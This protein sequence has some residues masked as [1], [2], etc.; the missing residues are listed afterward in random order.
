[1]AEQARPIEDAREERLNAAILA[2]LQAKAE[3]RRLERDALAARYPDVAEELHAFLGAEEAVGMAL[4]PWG[5]AAPPSTESFGS[6]DVEGV[7]N[8]GGMGVIL[9]CRDRNL[10]RS[11]A[12]KLPHAGATNSEA[13]RRFHEEAQITSQ[14]QHP[15]V[16]PVHELGRH[17]DGRPY[18]AMKLV[19]G[20]GLAELLK[21]RPTP[22]H[23][24]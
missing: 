12:V 17:P 10:N 5:R 6:F 13:L 16:P 11:L 9:R 18:F 14:L 2:H 19:V 22:A 24:L 21:D 15:G 23:D 8:Q 4:A 7:I 1:M 3:G 20:R